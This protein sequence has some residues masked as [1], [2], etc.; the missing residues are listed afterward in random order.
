MDEMGQ[1]KKKPTLLVAVIILAVVVAAVVGYFVWR[2]F[3]KTPEER[4]AESLDKAA[5][6][7]VL[8]EV[9]SISNPAAALPTTNPIEQVNPFGKTYSNPF[10]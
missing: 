1:E 10:K 2:N 4:A 8:P 6:G 7:S 5:Q 9:G 3:S